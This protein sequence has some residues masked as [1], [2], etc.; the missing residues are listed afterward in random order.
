VLWRKYS[1]QRLCDAFATLGNHLQCDTGWILRLASRRIALYS[2]AWTAHALRKAVRRMGGG[3]ASW[4]AGG[5][6]NILF[7]VLD[8]PCNGESYSA[9]LAAG[10][11]ATKTEGLDT[12]FSDDSSARAPH[13]PRP[14]TADRSAAATSGSTAAGRVR[15]ALTPRWPG[16]N[17]AR[18]SSQGSSLQGVSRCDS[19][20]P[21]EREWITHR[22]MARY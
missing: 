3:R 9:E 18:H 19:R 14:E 17:K 2:D 15:T 1:I 7:D 10:T 11:I 6:T 20:V 16:L 5:T 4:T 13:S 21:G 8:G 12:D 22:K